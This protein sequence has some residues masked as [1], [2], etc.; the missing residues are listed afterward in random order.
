MKILILVG[1]VM[2]TALLLLSAAAVFAA[3][4]DLGAHLRQLTGDGIGEPDITSAVPP[5]PSSDPA[6]I[7]IAVAG[8]VGTGG[9]EEYRT[10]AAIDGQ[11]ATSEY[12]A[13]VLL[14]DNVYPNGDPDEIESAVF[15]PFAG[16]LDG[17]TQLLPVLGN[18]DVR[19]G[20]G[21]DQADA[22]GM[23]N[24]WYATEIGGLLLV[25]LDSTQPDDPAQLAWLESTL[26]TTDAVWIVA[27]MHH[28]PYSSGY[29]GSSVDVRDAFSPLFE[30]FG[31]QLVL[32]GHDHDYQRSQ[33]INGVTY[34]VSGG[35]AMLRPASQA[36]FTEVAWST[37]HFVDLVVWPDRMEIRAVNQ[38]GELFD[39]VTLT[40]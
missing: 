16:V 37:Y 27:A 7:H 25:S 5:I 36:T 24:R 18:H 2:A 20:N 33:P 15:E 26:E 14:G 39:S 30:R 10:A 21:D 38:A 19:D 40:P 28:P 22:I 8:D 11:E 13:L 31:V 29:H 3:R 6:P 1:S 9:D 17:D 4:P 32:A 23:P 35:A 34:V 12:D